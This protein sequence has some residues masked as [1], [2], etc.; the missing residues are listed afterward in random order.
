MQPDASWPESWLY[1]YKYDLLELYGDKSSPGY[2]Y[3]Y[4]NRASITKSL[5]TSLAAP[6]ARVLDVAGGQGNMSLQ[7]AELGYDVTWNDL[8]ADLGDYIR[9][10]HEHGAIR[11]QP[12]NLFD[13]EPSQLYDVVLLSEV[14]EHVA[15]PDEM[16]QKARTLLKLNG[17]VVLTTPNG[18]YF[19][20]P[21]PRFSD[22]SDPSMFESEQFKPD[23]DGH[24]FLLYVD[25]VRLLAQNADMRVKSLK[26]F[27][28]PLT[29]GHLKTD[30][31][32]RHL[33]ERL[34]W[35]V[36]RVTQKLRG[37][38]GRKLNVHLAAV[39][40]PAQGTTR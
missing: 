20:N 28:N 26:L 16:L 23:A 35:G 14:I 13:L 24:I 33:P 19:R 8:R 22:C 2:T 11:Y 7:L 15:H 17:H 38:V 37:A 10:K 21:L 30:E 3:A 39:M 29:T 27:T 25:E 6:P 5:I 12:G 40:A 1:S 31:V 4:E 18:E 9:L 36:E 32:L 34:V